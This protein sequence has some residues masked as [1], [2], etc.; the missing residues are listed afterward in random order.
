MTNT[1][2]GE[3]LRKAR[4]AQSLSLGQI[5]EETKISKFYLEAIEA[6]QL[7]RL[8]GLFFYKAFVRQ[9]ATR[10]KLDGKKLEAQI[11]AEHGQAEVN[12]A[13]LRQVQTRTRAGI[14]LNMDSVRRAAS[15]LSADLRLVYASVGLIVMLAAGSV[16]YTWLQHP[17]SR[18]TS[19]AASIQEAGEAG[20]DRVVSARQADFRQVVDNLTP[21]AGPDSGVSLSLSALEPTWVTISAEGRV[22]YTGIIEPRQSKMLATKNNVVVKVGNAAGLEVKWNGKP[23]PKLGDQ[24]QVRTILFTEKEYQIVKPVVP[25]NTDPVSD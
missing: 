21:Q 14:S 18:G 1:T 23:L 24:K 25:L 3:Q 8:P 5:S 13:E 19:E 10:L 20:I 12:L 7:E 11:V 15:T 2:V 17:S 6:N 16:V 22:L 9:Y 4:A